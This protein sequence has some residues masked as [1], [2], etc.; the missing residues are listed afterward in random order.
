MIAGYTQPQSLQQIN[1]E[2]VN[3]LS[4]SPLAAKVLGG[5]LNSNKDSKTT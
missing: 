1:K 4:G 3:K 2:M 5:L